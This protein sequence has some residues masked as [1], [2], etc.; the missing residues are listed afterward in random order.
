[1]ITLNRFSYHPEGTLGVM[2]LPDCD[3]PLYSVE[4]PWLDNEPWKSCIPEGEYD[5]EWRKSPKFGWCYEVL[6]VINRTNILIHAANYPKNVS[7]CIGLGM[8]LLGDRIAVSK[9]RDAMGFFHDLTEGKPW[10]LSIVNAPYAA[11]RSL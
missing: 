6:D 9:S 2:H 5:L 4:R 3:Q 1:M 11:L 10:R 8:G 7:G